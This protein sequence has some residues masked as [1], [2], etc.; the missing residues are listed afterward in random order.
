MNLN[1]LEL[2]WLIC[3][4]FQGLLLLFLGLDCVLRLA[5]GVGRT[6]G[7]GACPACVLSL[8]HI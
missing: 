1:G 7:G 4:V 5:R 6:A 2:L 8:I 3:T